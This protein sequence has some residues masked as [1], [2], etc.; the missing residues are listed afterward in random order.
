MIENVRST[1]HTVQD[2]C[3]ILS[4]LILLLRLS[5]PLCAFAHLNTK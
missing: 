5:D 3:Y 4:I 2:F 1:A